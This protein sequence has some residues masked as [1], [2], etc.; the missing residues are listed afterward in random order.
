MEINGKF[1]SLERFLVRY[2]HLLLSCS[3]TVTKPHTGPEN[4]KA[5]KII[6]LERTPWRSSGQDSTLTQPSAWVQSHK[7]R[8]AAKSKKIIL[9][10]RSALF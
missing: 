7:P 10:E 6:L 9:L 2:P 4:S 8:G 1:I 3:L 5:V